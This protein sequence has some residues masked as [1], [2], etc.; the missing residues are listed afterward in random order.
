MHRL[1]ERVSSRG[2]VVGLAV[3]LAGVVAFACAGV[4]QATVVHRFAGTFGSPGSGLGQLEEPRGV[5]VNDGVLSEAAGDVYVADTGNDRIE[6]FSSTGQ[7]LGWF[8]GSGT[9][10]VEGKVESGTAA[11]FG[12]Q[13]GE[14][15]TGKLSKPELIAVDDSSSPLDPSR[16]DVY[17][18][19]RGSGVIDKFSAVGAYIGQISEV[20]YLKGLTYEV[21][22]GEPPKEIP[23]AEGCNQRFEPSGGYRCGVNGIV[24]DTTGALW[25]DVEK[26]QIY[27]FNDGLVNVEE[28]ERITEFGLLFRKLAVDGEDDL[29]IGF[30]WNSLGEYTF[31]KVAS[32]GLALH[33]HFGEGDDIAVDTSADEVY[34]D[35]DTG[36]SAYT[37]GDEPVESEASGSLAPSFGT[38]HLT[39]SVALGVSSVTHDV[40]AADLRADRVAIFEAVALPTVVLGAPSGRGT[41]GFTLNGTVNPEG[42]PVSECAFEY[43]T[44]PYARGE[45]AHGTRLECAPSS[46]SIGS[47]DGPVAVSASVSGLEP[48][49]AYYYRLVA[50]NEVGG[51]EAVGGEAFTGPRLGAEWSTDVAATSATLDGEVSPEGADTHYFF[52]YGPSEAYG[53]SAPLPEPGADIGAGTDTQ[54]VGAHLDGLVPASV[55]HYRLVVVQDGEEFAGP[56]RQFTSGPAGSASDSL[57]DARSW[58]LVSP[59]DKRGALIELDEDGGETQAAADGSA[60]A[61][62]SKGVS[63]SEAAVGK[64]TEAQVLS[65]REGSGWG[66]ADITLPGRL[67]EGTVSAAK[68]GQ[69]NPEYQLFSPDL[70]LAAVDPQEAG[71]PPLAPQVKERTLY[72]RDNLMGSY[73]PLV[74]PENASGPS[75]VAGGE[76]TNMHF[77]AATPDLKHVVFQSPLALT[78]EAIGEEHRGEKQPTGATELQ[79]N[80]YEWNAEDQ[81]LHLVNIFPKERGVAHELPLIRLAAMT[82]NFGNGRGGAQREMSA[83]GRRIAWTWG[84]PYEVEGG[85]KG[86]FV[87]DMVEERTLQVGGPGAR[88]QTMSSD[89]SKIFYLEDGEL[90]EYLWPLEAEAGTSI[91]LTA[92][93]APGAPGIGEEPSSVQESVSDVS[94][95]GS[96]VYFVADGVL[97][98]GAENGKP[99]LYLLREGEGGGWEA[100]KL[101]AT[102]SPLDSP[103]WYSQG[104]F[105]APLLTKVSSRV[106]PDGRYLAF[107]SLLPLTGYDNAD[108]VSGQP[109]EEVYLYD[110]QSE[111]L[112]CASCN[113]T[114]ERP[115]GLLDT[116]AANLLVDRVGTWSSNETQK[117]DEKVDHSLAGSVPGWSGRKGGPSTY[118]PRYL[119]D[120]GRLF[121][122]SPDGLVSQDTNGV[123]D[124][125]EFEPR[126]LGGCSTSVDSGTAVYVSE[127]AGSPVEGCVG[128]VSAGSSSAESAFYDASESGDDVFFSTTEKLTGEDYDTAYDIYDARVCSLTV[129]CRA[130]MQAAPECNSGDACKPAPSAQPPIFGAPP[131]ATFSGQGNVSVSSSPKAMPRIHGV[132]KPLSRAQKLK[133]ALKACR[134]QKSRRRR[135]ACEGTARHKYGPARKSNTGHESGRGH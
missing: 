134:K 130:A 97:A 36:I 19:D 3:V 84:M 92:N 25:V 73:L 77:L 66:S 105:G 29:Y 90:Y 2:L 71:V 49:R 28:S 127:I 6:R 47:G 20:H 82:S 32:S 65:R 11:G 111:K 74:T 59:P 94:E 8:D 34:L 67:P 24:V 50:A 95:N 121:F 51:S 128:L 100:P 119:S 122:D 35:H 81:T 113:P 104:L 21:R 1:D 99:N 27:S 93:R 109:D 22:E 91:E 89:G 64:K 133:R 107:M 58:E 7:F 96:Y 75:E 53:S 124:V 42:K 52:Q 46:A 23:E 132:S 15:E 43:D 106:S 57:I 30:G 123:E 16:E 118:Q 86:L 79:W 5:A 12:G 112:V 87:R 135:T 26:G 80:L 63:V 48:Q 62:L 85:Y 4:A 98:N 31:S 40:Y 17:V 13:P 37:T 38:G 76:E 78:P 56:D 14:V 10:D 55:Y 83:D 72:I 33:P 131:S 44:R 68:V 61:Y 103:S 41:H 54:T 114:G 102:L 108:A 101:I 39:L 126:G 120:S 117:S 70:S 129:P 60:I 69:F 116:K 125:Y 18:V 9:Y 45:A 110:A 88:Y 115:T